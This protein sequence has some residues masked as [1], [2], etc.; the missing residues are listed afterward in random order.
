MTFIQTPGL[1]GVFYPRLSSMLRRYLFEIVL[2]VLIL[3]GLI[4]AA[5]YL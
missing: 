1:P 5:F 2:A 4:A 3:C